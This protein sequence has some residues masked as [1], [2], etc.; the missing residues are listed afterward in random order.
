MMRSIY[1]R[2]SF[3]LIVAMLIGS[4]FYIEF[5]SNE[6]SIRNGV[7]QE[8]TSIVFANKKKEIEAT[9]KMM[10]E[11]ARTVSLMPSIRNI[12]VGNRK[13]E[14]EDVVKKGEF[15]EDAFMTVQQLYNNLANNVAVSEVYAIVKGLDYAQGEFPFFMF[16]SL[17]LNDSQE[18]DEADAEVNDDFPEEAEDAEY[19]YYPLQIQ[20]FQKN[21]PKF[22]F[23]KLDDIPAVLSPLMRTCDNTQYLSKKNGDVKESYGLLYSIPFYNIKNEVNGIFSVIFRKNI[24]E[25]K[26]VGVPFIILT[27]E[28]KA[29]AL[30]ESFSMPKELSPFLI[31]NKQ[32][33][34]QVYD[35][36]N[37][38]L[39]QHLE[40]YQNKREDYVVKMPLQIKDGSEW[41]LSMEIPEELYQ[42]ALVDAQSTLRSKIVFLTL[43]TLVFIGII[44]YSSKKRTD[45]LV[46]IKAFETI[47]LDI[48]EGSGNL[49]ASISQTKSDTIKLI[50]VYINQFIHEMAQIV[51]FSKESAVHLTESS[52][53]L[54]ED[55]NLL[56]NNIVTQ[57]EEIQK[58]QEL[59]KMTDNTVKDGSDI[60]Q[61]TMKD[62]SKTLHVFDNFASSLMEV[63]QLIESSSN[64]QNEV[65][66]KMELLTQQAAQIR[67]VLALIAEIADQTNLLAL[68]AAIEAARAGEHGR[69]FAVVADEVRKLAER[70]QGGLNEINNTTNIITSSISDINQELE[71]S[72]KSV[73]S[74]SDKAHVLMED[75]NV[76]KERLSKTTE[77]T[78]TLLAKNNEIIANINTLSRSM[79]HIVELSVSNQSSGE[80]VNSVATG[81]QETAVTFNSKLKRFQV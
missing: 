62:L 60:A 16:D 26:L 28:D 38:E 51:G 35:R 32:F 49:K 71:D 39:V 2:I 75:A 7:K 66:K 37:S 12:S 40:S 36:R 31:E 5:N 4:Y 81:L 1:L 69:G 13:S 48:V 3:I 33:D 41:T 63:S 15:S 54:S 10:Y 21:Y 74:V 8:Q 59:L 53:V 20:Y 50:A 17:V 27:E 14:E 46:D 78:N 29:Q 67:V 44:I 30:K 77:L 11:S 18:S 61:A 64:Q 72:A 56:Q 34:I 19:M 42:A 45:E 22:A 23:E 57:F 79:N 80:R 70:T 24:L 55:V 52:R 73:L 65:V 6:Q 25:A 76:T 43:M 58:G 68:N 47:V 9:F